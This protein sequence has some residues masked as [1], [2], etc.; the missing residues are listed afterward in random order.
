MSRSVTSAVRWSS[1]SQIGRQALSVSSTAVLAWLVAPEQFGLLSMAV[2]VSGFVELFR[3]MGTTA[4]VV[5]R[6]AVTKE[7]LSSIFWLNALLG[8]AAAAMVWIIAPLVGAWYGDPRVVDVLRV[9]GFGFVASGLGGLHQALLVRELRFEELAK[10]ELAAALLGALAGVVLATTG[11][12]VWSLVGITLVTGLCTTALA[13]TVA[14][15][16]PLPVLYWKEALSVGGFSLHLVGFNVVNYFARNADN[17]LIGRFL[18]A[19]AL[20]FYS[21]AYRIVLFPIRNVSGALGRVMFP[22]MAAVQENDARLRTMYLNMVSAIALVTF[23]MM[24]GVLATAEPLVALLLGAAWQPIVPLVMIFAA[25]GAIQSIVSSLGSIYL[26]KGRSDLLM[27]WGVVASSVTVASFVVGLRWGMV[28]V[29]GAYAAASVLLTLFSFFVPF[30]LVGLDGRSFFAVL[31]RPF[32]ASIL[33]LISVLVV[34]GYLGPGLTPAI[35]L[36]T[37]VATGAGVYLAMSWWINRERLLF[38]VNSLG[39]NP[40]PAMRGGGRA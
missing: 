20:G 40:A 7:F 3:D 38:V 8:L 29:A 15:W 23:P 18:G 22:A 39:V 26:A 17:F 2:A 34:Q 25:L 35:Q 28:G 9:L 21:L 12:Q 5:Q 36:G 6:K 24:L 4:A 13:W 37:L 16:R 19:E 1:V 10:L 27:W 14:R 30:R 32:A 33:M 31:W 11:A